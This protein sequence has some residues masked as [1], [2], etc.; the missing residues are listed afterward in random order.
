MCR[1]PFL[2]KKISAAVRGNYFL[3][4]TLFDTKIALPMWDG[5][6]NSADKIVWSV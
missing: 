6:V 1:L 5:E 3:K 4:I 2:S